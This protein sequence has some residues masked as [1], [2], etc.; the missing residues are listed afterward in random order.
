MKLAGAPTASVEGTV[1]V[2]A[3]LAEVER[4]LAKVGPEL[5]SERLAGHA[6]LSVVRVLGRIERRAGGARL[7]LTQAAAEAGAWKAAGCRSPEEWAAREH[8]STVGE[9]RGDLQASKRLAALPAA[10]DAARSGEISK[11]AARAIAEGASADPTSERVL[12]EKARTG[13]LAAVRDAARRA[14]TRAD[15]RD[16]RAAQRMYQRRGLEAWV[17]LDGEG[18]GVWNVPPAYQAAFLAALEP[19]REEGPRWS[20]TSTTPPWCAGTR[21]T[22]RC[23]RS[24]A[25]GRSPSRWPARSPRTPC[26]GSS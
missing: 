5:A 2:V 9:A 15:E 3:R 24:P 10:R 13:D 19:Y 6:V 26:C 17:E 21:V 16:G 4:L 7:V 8:G 23:A 14:R 18:R 22:A 20:C 12:V 25:S 11:D 1:D